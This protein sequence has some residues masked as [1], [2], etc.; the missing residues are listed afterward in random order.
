MT[1]SACRPFGPR[2][3]SN[4]TSAPSSSVRYPFIWIA[5]NFGT[6]TRTWIYPSQVNGWAMV[7]P[8]K[9]SSW[10]LLMTISYVMVA[11]VNRP[12]DYGGEP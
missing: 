12:R 8:G 6:L 7:P 10:F 11:W 9:L 4:S 5:E 1:F 3:T 2:F